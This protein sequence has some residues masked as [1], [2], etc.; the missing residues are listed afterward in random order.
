MLKEALHYQELGYPVIPIGENSK[1]PEKGFPLKEFLQ[2]HP[3]TGELYAWFGK[4]GKNRNLAIVT[5]EISNLVVLDFESKEAAAE[6]WKNMGASTNCISVTRRGLHFL[7]RHAGVPIKNA[8]KVK[9]QNIEYDIRG[10]GGYIMAPPSTVNGHTYRWHEGFEI[11]SPDDLPVFNPD[12]CPQDKN[13]SRV[14]IAEDDVFK[15]ISRARAYIAR[16]PGAISGQ[17]GHDATFRVACKLIHDFALQPA[18]AFPLILQW[19]STC[20]PPWSERELLHKLHDA[21]KVKG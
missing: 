11:C 4:M 1:T 15:R 14:E 5:G 7:F 20:L 16:I 8:V 12:W 18:E 6:A 19:N 21:A 9:N 17:N 3:T 10:D 2:R 13:T